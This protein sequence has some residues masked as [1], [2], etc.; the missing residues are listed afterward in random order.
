MRW[1]GNEFKGVVIVKFYGDKLLSIAIQCMWFKYVIF[2]SLL[3]WATEIMYR[4][5]SGGE[6][7]INIIRLKRKVNWTH[8]VREMIDDDAQHYLHHITFVWVHSAN[9]DTNFQDWFF[10][11][12]F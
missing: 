6:Y 8:D 3:G 5:Q 1:K 7:E 11:M 2:A 9:V 12:T 4:Q 10:V